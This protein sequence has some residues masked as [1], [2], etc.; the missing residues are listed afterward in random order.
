M[1]IA[2]QNIHSN[3]N[4]LADEG[5][6]IFQ[7]QNSPKLNSYQYTGVTDE[8][9]EHDKDDPLACYHYCE[10]IIESYREKEVIFSVR[11]GYMERQP[12]L[13]ERMRTILVDWLIEVH[14][15][16]R[17]VP[18]TIYLAVNIVDRYLDIKECPQTK[19]QLVGSTALLIASKY[20][21]IFPPDL[22]DLV[23]I[24]DGAYTRQDVRIC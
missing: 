6:S 11:P 1:P 20:E 4:S 10:D 12:E 7:Q 5:D 3:N 17:M 21:E 16:F 13:N 22:R 19:F 23:Y 8:I 24:C 9:D 18:E 14:H 15:K 2:L